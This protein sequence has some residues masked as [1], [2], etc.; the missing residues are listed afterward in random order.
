ME[1]SL[2][3]HIEITLH[4]MDRRYEQRFAASENAVAKAERGI[5]ERLNS[6]NEFRDAL[7]DQAN[8]MA[9]RIELER[10]DLMVQEL[11]RAKANFDGRLIAM[12]GGLSI[13]TSILIWALARLV[14]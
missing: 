14:G 10:V 11:Q 13:G 5:N 7:R 4:E 8:R 1:V 12:A 3:E 2:R 9:T 6:M